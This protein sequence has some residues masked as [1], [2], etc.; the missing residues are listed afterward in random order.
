MSAQ[1]PKR[2]P[3]RRLL[4]VL[5][6]S[7]VVLLLAMAAVVLVP[8]LTHQS[9]G[10]S[11]Q[12]L[13]SGFVSQSEAKGADG[14][15]R[16]LSVETLDG[17]DVDMQ[18]L[19]PGQVIAVRG[20]GYDPKIGIYVSICKVPEAAGEK[21]SPCLGGLP[22]GAMEGEAAGSEKPMS[23]FWITGDWAWKA[24][25]NKNYDDPEKGEFV[26][27]LMVPPASQ[28]GLDCTVQQCAVTTRADH[29]AATDRVQDM[30]LPVKF[31]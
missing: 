25:A 14:R 6:G 31:G 29:T 30:M 21:P 2:K 16:T 9:A 19:E 10:G 17:E 13:P 11:G 4:Y 5:L 22:E 3:S 28:E 24:F 23:S 8:I 18:K 20:T 15:T 7:A 12:Q 26:V 27:H 1:A